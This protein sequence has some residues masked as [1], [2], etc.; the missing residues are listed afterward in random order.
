[1]QGEK[2]YS[3]CLRL[4]RCSGCHHHCPKRSCG[5]LS[6]PYFT[7]GCFS[8]VLRMSSQGDLKQSIFCRPC[9]NEA[10]ITLAQAPWA[11]P[12]AKV[13]MLSNKLPLPLIRNIPTATHRVQGV[14]SNLFWRK[15]DMLINVK[16]RHYLGKKGKLR[17]KAPPC[18]CKAPGNVT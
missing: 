3:P 6:K 1:M 12:G 15:A 16:G 11:E 8:T 4:L 10:N 14:K 5:M 2:L 18:P 9:Q 17:P 13:S 7:R